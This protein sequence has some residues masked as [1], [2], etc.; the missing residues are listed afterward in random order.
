MKR[1]SM[2]L[3]VEARH[4]GRLGERDLAQIER[5]LGTCPDCVTFAGELER[6][7]S[8]V[9]EIMPP[10]EPVALGRMR[11]R[12][13]LLRAATV[14]ED[15]PSRRIRFGAVAAV[16]G[17]VAIAMVI[18]TSLFVRNDREAPHVRPLMGEV[19]ADSAFTAF[20]E[21]ADGSR[22]SRTDEDGLHQVELSEGIVAIAVRH[23]REHERFVVHTPDGEVEVRGTRFLVE[24]RDAHMTRVEV[25]EG[26]VE[27]RVAG[28]ELTLR[29]HQKWTAVAVAPRE[30]AATST[31]RGEPSSFKLQARAL[32]RHAHPP[33]T[34]RS[35]RASD[36]QDGMRRLETGDFGDAA[37]KLHKF[38]E[39]HA[40]DPR[41]EDALFL[42]AMSLAR[43][44]RA[45]EAEAAARRYLERY[46]NGYRHLEATRLARTGKLAPSP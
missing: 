2:E 10:G 26:V 46:P 32:P 8:T 36:F 19:R 24:V 23:L 4:D 41:A 30:P 31:G 42:V 7:R 6:F 3:L 13:R 21:G 22:F 25:E 14:S 18:V 37:G 40:T 29:A 17:T 27:V 39:E 38:A 5:H 45:E 35:L 34:E 43:A 20:V 16:V 1:C 33:T 9:Q 11:G 15:T 12:L 44:G 28:A